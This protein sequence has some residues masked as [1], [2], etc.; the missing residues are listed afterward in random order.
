M[1]LS[2]AGECLDESTPLYCVSVGLLGDGCGLDL[3]EEESLLEKEGE[4]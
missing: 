4:R 2:S 1:L 3:S